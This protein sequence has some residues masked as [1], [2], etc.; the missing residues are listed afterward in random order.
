MTFALHEKLG[1]VATVSLLVATFALAAC[2][3]PDAPPPP[4]PAAPPS[5][6]WFICDGID[7]PAAFVFE[8]DG[9][10][11]RVA[12]YDKPNGAIVGRNEY[13]LG[14][15]D[16]AAGSVFMA[17]LDN[18][19]EIGAIRRTNAQMLE[20]PGAAYTERFSTVKFGEREIS[21]RWMPRTRV[22]GLTGRRSFVVYEDGSGDLIYASY[23]FTDAA[24]QPPIELSNNAR[25]TPFS[26][27][28]RGGEETLSPEGVSYGFENQGYRYVVALQRDGSGR[29]DVMQA[30]ATI[31]SE[32]LIAFQQGS[33]AGE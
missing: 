23:N 26:V 3:Q 28:A 5:T 7:A 29:L 33:G 13:T 19:A 24:Q 25:T 18:G 6:V 31:Q 30:G 17:L 8:R 2:G 9:E 16:G 32:P 22:L 20:N 1:R 4:L 15:E 14:Q 21:C 10:S 12:E 11:V 27:E